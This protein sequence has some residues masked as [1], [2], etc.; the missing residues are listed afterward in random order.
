[1]TPRRGFDPV[2]PIAWLALFAFQ[3]PWL[4]ADLVPIHDTFYNFINFHVYYSHFF[5]EREL[6]HWYPYSALG[7]PSAIQQVIS[8][9]PVDYAVALAG[10]LLRI[11]DTML[12]F[13]I[14]VLAEQMVYVLGVVLL[15]RRAF[16]SR[17][18]ALLLGVAAA[19]SVVWYA[20]LWFEL[21]LFYLLPLVLYCVIGFL[22]EPA[23]SER[24]WY[25]GL[26]CVAWGFGN[27]PYFASLW[28]VV[29]LL[30]LAAPLVAQRSAWRAIVPRSRRSVVACAAFLG[31]AALFAYFG[32]RSLDDVMLREEGR[33]PTTG[34]VPLAVF[35]TYGG[36]AKLPAVIR[37]VLTGWPPQLPFGSG[38]DTSVY[39]GLLPLLAL[40]LAVV[41]ERA[42]LFFGTLAAVAF[43]VA[44]SLGGRVSTVAYHLP[45]FDGYRHIGLVYG[46]VKVLALF[47][48]GFGVERVAS[49]WLRLP[50][51]AAG[52]IAIAA[53]VVA[54]AAFARSGLLGWAAA[55][56]LAL[57]LRVA[58]YLGLGALS[59][60]ATRSLATGLLVALAFDLGLYQASVLARAPRLSTEYLAKT[61]AYDVAPMVYRPLR[62][63]EIDPASTL[64]EDQRSRDA[65]ALV[66]GP[67]G[68]L[69]WN[70]HNFT[71]VDPCETP[72]YT[73]MW[74]IRVYRLLLLEKRDGVDADLGDRI[75]CTLPK[76][77]LVAGAALFDTATD[78]R[79]AVI[80]MQ[81][82]PRGPDTVI[83]VIRIPP[84][85]PRPDPEPARPA[86]GRVEVTRF[87]PNG[88]EAT[89]HV[90]APG[91]AWLIYA[92]AADP[93][94]KAKI[95]GVPSWIYQ[96]NLAF[97][98]V[99][100]PAGAHVV[101]FEHRR[102]LHFLASHGVAGLGLALSAVCAALAFGIGFPRRA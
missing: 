51:R 77:R 87:T 89:V 66:A 55:W 22:Q 20:Q 45:T 49:R 6:V 82:T 58:V 81:G 50:D 25:A 70:T 13:K 23:R 79:E 67:G 43:V 63:D 33:D 90:D 18:T 83:D 65:A 2:L 59:F 8:F 40:G 36:I 85:A 53:G 54:A 44:F 69:Y 72:H 17:A 86:A 93:G 24:L 56:P 68:Q 27:P 92:D 91:G 61:H 62:T 78:A 38:I 46:L 10:A 48:A 35:L 15:A 88:I 84:G 19:G 34:A 11:R 42:A 1:V 98:A 14:S 96:A 76:L 101:R 99:R 47:A 5:L 94:W 37:G 52:W 12:L 100:V 26:V 75:G 3:W 64:P 60:A 41:R 30:V 95:D 21:R 32:L 73:E 28:A 29:L 7:Q 31:S 74:T 9:T 71:H 80:A 97:K 39:V 4:R 16:A 102:G 57:G